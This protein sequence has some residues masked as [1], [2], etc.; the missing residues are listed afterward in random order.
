MAD[1]DRGPHAGRFEPAEALEC[2]ADAKRHQH[3][4]HERDV[5]RSARVAGSLQASGVGQRHRDEESGYREEAEQLAAERHDDRI[6]EAENSQQVLRNQHEQRA[7]GCGD[8]NA[9]VAYDSQLSLSADASAF[10]VFDRD[11]RALRRLQ[12]GNLKVARRAAA[13]VS[14]RRALKLK[15]GDP[16]AYTIIAAASCALRDAQEATKAYEKLDD[17]NKGLAKSL[18]Q[19]SGVVIE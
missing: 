19:K 7:D 18:C 14:A 17:R 11:G 10:H 8:G 1:D 16:N 5:Q 9:E 12:P 13:L 2:S 4:G 3:L 15:P 6:V